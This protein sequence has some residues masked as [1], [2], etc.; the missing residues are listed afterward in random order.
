MFAES[1]VS[2]V[3][4]IIFCDENYYCFVLICTTKSNCMHLKALSVT[5]FSKKRGESIIICECAVV[6]CYAQPL[7]ILWARSSVAHM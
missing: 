7:L 1:T 4:N 2:L 3:D 5:F 6:V